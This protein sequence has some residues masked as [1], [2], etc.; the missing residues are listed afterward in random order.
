MKSNPEIKLLIQ[1]V[2]STIT[3]QIN[4]DEAAITKEY[5]SKNDNK[6]S[7]VIKILSV[8]G[9]LMA[10]LAFLGFLFLTGI[11]NSEAGLVVLGIIFIVGAIILNRKSDKL[12]LDTFTISLYII[13]GLLMI[14]GFFE[15]KV[16]EN[17]VALIVMF[18]TLI[19][20]YFSQNYVLSFVSFTIFNISLV[21]LLVFLNNSYQLIHLYA[22]AITFFLLFVFLYEAKIIRYSKKISR[23]YKP[24]L[25]STVI[26]YLI[27]LGYYATSKIFRNPIDNAW[28]FSIVLFIINLFVVSKI[29]DVLRFRQKTVILIAFIFATLILGIMA[30]SPAVLGVMLLILLSFYINNKMGFI[31]GIISFI[32][33]IGQFYYNLEYSLLIKSILLIS[34]G[35]LFLGLY[36]VTLKYINNEKV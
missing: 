35:L 26:I 34:S 12:V 5:Q 6:S 2:Q 14:T 33:F 20:L 29:I 16:D 36:F 31:L 28:F 10:T 17:I 22:I 15:Y 11:Y 25:A 8:I 1:D 18:I 9:S 24:V 21:S 32:Y 23:L 3:Q 7:V 27:V 30:F 13:G 4:F 19:T